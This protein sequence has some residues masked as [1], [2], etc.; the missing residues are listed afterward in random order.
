METEDRL[1]R[2]HVRASEAPVSL[3]PELDLKKLLRAL[4][5][6]RD[7][8]FTV[9]LPSDRIGLAG[10]VADTFNEIVASNQRMAR[11]ME[12]AGRMVGK[13]GK[14]RHRVAMDRRVGAPMWLHRAGAL[15]GRCR[16]SQEVPPPSRSA[17]SQDPMEWP[18]PG[19][20]QHCG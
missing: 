17:H 12:R 5:A 19:T 10:K 18:A 9:R 11:E 8:D 2:R 1:R 3:E 14:T 6:V 20:L 7:G 16:R 15:P 4:Q 13:E